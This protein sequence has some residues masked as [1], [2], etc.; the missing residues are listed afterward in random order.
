MRVISTTETSEESKPAFCQPLYERRPRFVG[1]RPG[2]DDGDAVGQLEGVRQ[3]IA[4]GVGNRDGD[5]PQSR[6]HYSTGGNTPSAEAFRSFAVHC[7]SAPFSRTG[8][9]G[10]SVW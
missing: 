4:A 8:L 6:P 7:I 9:D 1:D 10:S 5:R 3:D 2:V